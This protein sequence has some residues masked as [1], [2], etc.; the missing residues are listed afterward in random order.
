MTLKK[1]TLFEEIESSLKEHIVPV[2]PLRLSFWF[3]TL[4]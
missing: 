4:L 3:R 1:F 2:P